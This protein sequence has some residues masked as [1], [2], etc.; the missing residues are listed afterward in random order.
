MA[1]LRALR[2]STIP[3]SGWRSSP[4]HT[5]RE[6]RAG[7]S[8]TDRAIRRRQADHDIRGSSAGRGE[9]G[10]QPL[11][12][13]R[14][15]VQAGREHRSLFQ[16]F[17]P[18][19]LERRWPAILAFRRTTSRRNRAAHQRTG[20]GRALLWFRER[21]RGF[22]PRP[23]ALANIAPERST[24]KLNVMLRGLAEERGECWTRDIVAKCNTPEMQYF[25]MHVGQGLATMEELMA[26]HPNKARM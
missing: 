18:G 21:W 10:A 4:L 5:C 17:L 6:G 7:D 14:P 19:R 23:W 20:I 8:R 24:S 12:G 13:Q 25:P 11:E 3:R 22:D 2:T 15:S 26:E 9:C 16:G 1:L